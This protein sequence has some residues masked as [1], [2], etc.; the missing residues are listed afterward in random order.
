MR[1]ASDMQL[2]DRFST[3]PQ[4]EA[5]AAFETLV[6]RHGPM[7]LRVCREILIDPNDADDAFQATFLALVRSAA[8]IRDRNSLASWLFG[9]ARRVAMRARADAARRREIERQGAR[10][11]VSEAAADRPLVDPALF[12][13]VDRLP[14]NYRAPIVLC[15]LEGSTH[16]AAAQQLGWP[17]GTVRGRLARARSLLRARLARRG[18][19]VPSALLGAGLVTS[20]A[21]AA[22]PALLARSTIES[23]RAIAAGGAAAVSA[24]V[25]AW[26]ESGL[27]GGAF[28]R[29]KAAA[30]LVGLLGAVGLGLVALWGV[31]ASPHPAQATHQNARERSSHEDQTAIQGTWSK[32]D[33]VTWYEGGIA[34]PPKRYKYTWSVTAETITTTNDEGFASDISQ[35]TLDPSVSPKTIEMKSLNRGFTL[36]GIYKL[37]GD[38][39][40]ICFGHECPTEFKEGPGHVLIVLPR[41]SRTPVKL[42]T[43]YP[44]APGCYWAWEP[45]GGLPS[46][47]ANSNGISAFIKKDPQGALIVNLASLSRIVDG[48]PEREYRPVAFDKQKKRYLFGTGEGGSTSMAQFREIGL[49]HN[50][51]RLEPERLPFDR[52]D[53]LGIEVVPAEVRRAEKEAASVVAM[54]KARMAGIEILPR[55]ELGKPFEFAL[56]AS[57]G[58]PLRSSGLK[59]KVVLIDC[60]ATWCTPCVAKMPQ[61]KTLYAQR[62]AAG[63]EVIGVNFDHDKGRKTTAAIIQKLGLSWPEFFVPDDKRDLWEKATGINSL[64]RLLLIDRSGILRWDG[65]P[66][67]MQEQVAAVARR[68]VA[69]EVARGPTITAPAAG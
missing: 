8:S 4:E 63:L 18:L 24:R 61:L 64:P 49:A 57:D 19:T 36:H 33:E 27:R 62:H 6:Q 20:Q 17:L 65:G 30:G 39:L 66:G 45:R 21:R 46:S 32:M 48:K 41:E 52:V 50:E 2:L 35:Y 58:K 28:L 13:E 16:E 31:A 59:G 47:M 51:H 29:W 9:A 26:T 14:V 25:A 15:Y 60:W 54:N 55:P 44:T 42:T 53:R 69:E 11:A 23:A 12:E 37:E 67:E 40:T 5:G 1:G 68:L 7:V 22:I 43:E 10:P 34:Q 38:T 56:T 3:A